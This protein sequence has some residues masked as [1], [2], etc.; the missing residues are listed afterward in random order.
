MAL[1]IIPRIDHW[2]PVVHPPTLSPGG[3]HLWK[4]PTGGR[5]GSLG[6]LWSLLSRQESERAGKLKLDHHR[7]RYV[8][9]HA[10]LRMILSGYLGAAPEMIGFCYGEAGK[11]RLAGP[12]SGLEFNL[13]TSGDL[14]LVAL[15][16]GVPIGVDCEQ[17]GDRGDVVAIARRMFSSE[18]A[19][20]IAAADEEERLRRFHI[21]WTALEAEVKRDGRGLLGRDESAAR[22]VLSVRHCVPASGFIA[23]VVCERLPPVEDWVTLSLGVD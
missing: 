23:A 10:G 16:R 8:R 5:G 13:T 6:Q 15:A 19:S 2:H 11:S 3:L 21:A 1:R 14:A 12:C 4:I 22:S 20:R 7:E 18:Q 9:A 17:V